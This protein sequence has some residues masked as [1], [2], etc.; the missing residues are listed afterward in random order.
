MIG[1]NAAIIIHTVQPFFKETN[2]INVVRWSIANDRNDSRYYPISYMYS[3]N[4][5]PAGIKT[6]HVHLFGC[7]Q[8]MY[9]FIKPFLLK[10]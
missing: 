9:F 2:W 8:Q 4:S 10:K 6:S 3:R 1:Y 5:A 7:S